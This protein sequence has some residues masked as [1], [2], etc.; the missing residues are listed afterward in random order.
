MGVALPILLLC[1]NLDLDLDLCWKGG[2]E[3]GVAFPI[4]LV[5]VAKSV[6]ASGNRFFEA[7]FS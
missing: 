6:F 3:M 2:W 5:T 4:L 7:E 1:A